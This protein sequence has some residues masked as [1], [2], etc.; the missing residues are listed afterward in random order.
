MSRK[1]KLHKKLSTVLNVTLPNL[2]IL[3]IA[4]S[5][6][7]KNEEVLDIRYSAHG[8][9]YYYPEKLNTITTL[10]SEEVTI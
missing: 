4:H 3:S 6:F 2:D 5:P 1:E 10:R 7:H 9:P 8:S